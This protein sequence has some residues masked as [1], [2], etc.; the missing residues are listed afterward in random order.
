MDILC[1]GYLTG[2]IKVDITQ[3]SVGPYDYLLTL[4]GVERSVAF[5]N[6][7]STNYTFEFGSRYL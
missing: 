6:A 4:Q 1:F 5:F 7:A 2:A 3:Q